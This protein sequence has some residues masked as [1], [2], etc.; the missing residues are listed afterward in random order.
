M[1]P[2]PMV[3]LSGYASLN[4]Q[5]LAPHD[6]INVAVASAD[7]S[8]GLVE[9]SFG[10]PV[11]SRNELAHNGLSITGTDGWISIENATVNGKGGLRVTVRTVTKDEKGRDVG[12]AEEVIDEESR[13]VKVEVA[14]FIAA[15]DGKD[16]GFGRPLDAL[17][18]VAFIQAA[19]NSN[20]APVDLVKLV[21][22]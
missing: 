2:S 10:S 12:E 3:S 16:D 14:S 22:L 1:L 9:L 21:E 13:G 8:H 4:Q 19:L 17:K 20:G 18:D 15:I 11:P 6:T 5:H 7:G